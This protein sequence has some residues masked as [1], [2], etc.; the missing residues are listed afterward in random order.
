[1]LD[2]KVA[3]FVAKNLKRRA[4]QIDKEV[5]VNKLK[6][7]TKHQINKKIKSNEINTGATLITAASGAFGDQQF[8]VTNLSKTI[9]DVTRLNGDTAKVGRVTI[10]GFGEVT[11]LEL[12]DISK[13][14]NAGSNSVA[15]ITY[16]A[17]AVDI[18]NNMQ[19]LYDN[20]HA[21]NMTSI[22]EIVVNDGT[23]KGKKALTLSDT[24]FQVLRDIF[25]EGVD[26]HES[27]TP[28]LAKNYTFNVTG[29]DYS[30]LTTPLSGA[31][32]ALQD[33]IDVGSFAITGV[34]ASDLKVSSAQLAID[35]GK[36]KLKTMTSA[37]I[38][39]VDRSIIQG[40][41]S[42]VGSG[43]DRAKLKLVNQL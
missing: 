24:Y 37:G 18:Q 42:S 35:L 33:E 26:K 1:L 21:A 30:R 11:A 4:H 8:S 23:S 25:K 43:P 16:S 29:A 40:L 14:A 12:S 9:S 5:G 10:K 31:P 19:A 38:N 3:M 34:Q 15:Q 20:Q 17:K 41:L 28:V 39:S 36:S 6:F 22:T 27:P 2:G 13:K 7:L 32:L